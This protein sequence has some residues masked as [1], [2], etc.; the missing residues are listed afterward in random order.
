MDY[1][2]T[3]SFFLYQQVYGIHE[4][5]VSNLMLLLN[6][7]SPRF[8]AVLL[9]MPCH[10]EDKLAVYFKKSSNERFQHV[11]FSCCKLEALGARCCN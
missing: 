9:V 1:D 8:I 4:E 3:I 11:N 2:L 10:F 7:S 6:T 5:S